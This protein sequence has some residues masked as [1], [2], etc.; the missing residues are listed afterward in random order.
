MT[1]VFICH[2][3][4]DKPVVEPI[5]LALAGIGCKVFYD[6]QSLPPGGDYHS[7]IETA[8]ARCD[9]FVFVASKASLASGKYTLSELGLAHRRWPS[10]ANRVIPVA[11]Q[12]TRPTELPAY[13]QAVTVLEVKGN[14]AAEVR[15]AVVAVL[16]AR[17]RRLTLATAGLGLIAVATVF[18]IPAIRRGFTPS[19]HLPMSPSV[20]SEDPSS[21]PPTPEIGRASCRERV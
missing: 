12:G 19:P 20:S 21:R 10:P 4:E 3:S 5:Q 14:A 15:I 1:K 18:S 7:R 2:A 9:V 13:L 11:I 16:R 6:E 8:I 17:S